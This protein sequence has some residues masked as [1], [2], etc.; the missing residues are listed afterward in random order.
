MAGNQQQAPAEIAA[1][2]AAAQ[3][4]PACQNSGVSSLNTTINGYNTGQAI[5]A[6]LSA[7]YPLISQGI[8]EGLEGL[9]LVHFLHIF[10]Q[11]S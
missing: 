10:L 6:Q 11:R 3:R 1:A 4:A 2:I 8:F 5:G 9:G 7:F